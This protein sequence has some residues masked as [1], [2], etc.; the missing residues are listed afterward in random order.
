MA[1]QTITRSC[2]HEETIQ[3]YGPH[4]D[5][6]RKAEYEAT[7]LCRECWRAQAQAEREEQSRTA[8]QRNKEQGLPALT[9]SEKQIAWAESIRAEK[10]A[11][12]ERLVEQ[13][14][15]SSPTPEQRQQFNDAIAAVLAETAASWWIDNRDRTARQI[16]GEKIKEG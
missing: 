4:K 9:G 6:A 7:K 12:L 2:G 10:Q 14:A 13:A 8:A 5:R 1:K 11:E 15:K 16:V 3:I